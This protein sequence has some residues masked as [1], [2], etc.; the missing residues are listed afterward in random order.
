MNPTSNEQAPAPVAPEQGAEQAGL[1]L[2]S[3]EETVAKL[4]EPAPVELVMARDGS[5]TPKA[6]VEAAR[7]RGE[8][9]RTGA[10]Q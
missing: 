7:A 3:M 1:V 6:D 10:Y 8:D 2:P 9:M 4:D 5:L